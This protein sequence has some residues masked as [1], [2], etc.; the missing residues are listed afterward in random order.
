MMYMYWHFAVVLA[1]DFLG[2]PMS[3]GL[4]LRN[5]LDKVARERNFF[6]FTKSLRRGSPRSHGRNWKS[7]E[8]WPSV[9]WMTI[10]KCGMPLLLSVGKKSWSILT[11]RCAWVGGCSDLCHPSDLYRDDVEMLDI[12]PERKTSNYLQSHAITVLELKHIEAVWTS[13]FLSKDH[14]LIWN[15]LH[16]ASTCLEQH[17][18]WLRSHE[19]VWEMQTSRATAGKVR[20]PWVANDIRGANTCNHLSIGVLSVCDS[21][22]I[23]RP[24]QTHLTNWTSQIRS[25]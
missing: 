22:I 10:N 20:V 11:H 3:H 23:Q 1:A 25:S 15:Y 18:R 17:T 12:V 4:W 6:N 21:S 24:F 14:G 5:W 13:C 7:R 16:S 8:L 2:H 9:S 19:N